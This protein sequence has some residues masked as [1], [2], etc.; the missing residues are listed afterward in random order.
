MRVVLLMIREFLFL[1]FLLVNIANGQGVNE[2]VIRGNIE[3]AARKLGNSYVCF[4]NR[5]LAWDD[6]GKAVTDFASNFE[7]WFKGKSWQVAMRTI[8]DSNELKDWD[9]PFKGSTV[10]YGETNPPPAE[11]RICCF[12][13]KMYA[14]FLG[15]TDKK[16]EHWKGLHVTWKDGFSERIPGFVLPFLRNPRVRG[17]VLDSRGTF[18]DWLV[19]KDTRW[20]VNAG[21]SNSTLVPLSEWNAVPLKT[22]SDTFE[23]RTC[24]SVTFDQVVGLPLTVATIAEYRLN[25][26]TYFPTV[27][28]Y[29]SPEKLSVKNYKHY[30]GGL[31]LPESGELVTWQMDM[32]TPNNTF[33]PDEIVEE[34]WRSGEYTIDP[35]CWQSSLLGWQVH[36]ANPIN[37]DIDV[38]FNP[39]DKSLLVTKDGKKSYQTIKGLTEKESAV[40]LGTAAPRTRGRDVLLRW[41]LWIISI[42]FALAVLVLWKRRSQL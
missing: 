29:D 27:L 1:L 28:G 34:L 10:P 11:T 40:L 16:S 41:S 24:R 33:N 22:G 42:G 15:E 3:S 17:N 26:K 21:P 13:G 6:N 35:K 8:T 12:D 31:I 20:E 5:V 18:I 9:K 38:W 39:P 19:S 4:S 37:T 7:I 25:G 30:S 14:E 36:A 23:M 32:K 2:I